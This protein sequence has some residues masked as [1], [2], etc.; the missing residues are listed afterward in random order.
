MNEKVSSGLSYLWNICMGV[1]GSIS[2]DAY[3]V[4]IALAGMLITA[5][6]NNYWQKKRFERDYEGDSE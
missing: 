3:T 1:F 5:F 2:T 4:I 6:I